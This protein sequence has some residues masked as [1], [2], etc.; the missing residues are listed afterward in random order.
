MTR[1]LRIVVVEDDAVI[2]ALLAETLQGLGHDVCAV[3]ATEGDAVSASARFRP[4][5]LIVDVSL[6]HGS[7]VSAMATILRAGHVAHFFISGHRPPASL[8]GATVLQ[9]PFRAADLI[10]AVEQAVC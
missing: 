2:G 5:L 6:A 4:D 7:G 1:R 9:K 10:Q 8:A 3:A